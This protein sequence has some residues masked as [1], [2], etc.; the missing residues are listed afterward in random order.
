MLSGN[1]CKCLVRA[2]LEVGNTLTDQSI[3]S[4]KKVITFHRLYR[5]DI[6]RNRFMFP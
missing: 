3:L 4:V 2:A 5:F 6:K 1:T